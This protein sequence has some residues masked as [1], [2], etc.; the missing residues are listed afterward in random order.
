MKHIGTLIQII[1]ILLMI[2]PAVLLL[3]ITLLLAI[4]YIIIVSLLFIPFFIAYL[5]HEE[6]WKIWQANLSI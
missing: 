5:I 3:G 4:G 1:G 6:G 2:P